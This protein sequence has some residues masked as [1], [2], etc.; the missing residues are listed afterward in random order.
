MKIL[1]VMFRRILNEL[2]KKFSRTLKRANRQETG[3]KRPLAP[4][5]VH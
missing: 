1:F 5:R 4:P 2:K 3:V